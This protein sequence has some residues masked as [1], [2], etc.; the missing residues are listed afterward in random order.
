MRLQIDRRSSGGSLKLPLDSSFVSSFPG[1]LRTMD[2]LSL[3]FFPRRLLLARYRRWEID[4]GW[5]YSITA[6]LCTWRSSFFRLE[7]ISDCVTASRYIPRRRSSTSKLVWISPPRAIDRVIMAIGCWASYPRLSPDLW[8]KSERENCFHLQET[9]RPNRVELD[10]T[11]YL[12]SVCFS[13]SPVSESK[14]VGG[15][16]NPGAGVVAARYSSIYVRAL[17]DR[18]S[19]SSQCALSTSDF[20]AVRDRTCSITTST[21]CWFTSA[22]KFIFVNS[23][24]EWELNKVSRQ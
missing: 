10:S 21:H 2:C 13:P 20:Y 1:R 16:G 3:I 18:G 4:W 22:A 14:M 8:G 23:P 12:D 15:M 11:F 24:W 7:C 17:P 6:K 5:C 19:I 9:S